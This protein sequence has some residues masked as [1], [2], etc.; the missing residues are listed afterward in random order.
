MLP[1]RYRFLLHEPAFGCTHLSLYGPLPLIKFV[2]QRFGM[3]VKQV[4]FSRGD[5]AGSNYLI[6]ISGGFIDHKVAR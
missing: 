1:K 4:F 2:R 5:R 3:V 6:V